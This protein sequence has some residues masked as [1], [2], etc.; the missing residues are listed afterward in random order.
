MRNM[1]Y[2]SFSQPTLFDNPIFIVGLFLLAIIFLILIII[3]IWRAWVRK[4]YKLP[5]EL[6]SVIL[7]VAVPKDA[8]GVGKKETETGSNT[9]Q[10]QEQISW[11]ENLWSTFGAI[12]PPKAWQAW[13]YG[14]HDEISLEIVAQNRL[15]YFYVVAPKY[16]EQFIEQQ[17]QAQYPHAQIEI[18]EDYNIFAPSSSVA[19]ACLNLMKPDILSLKTYR[20]MEVDPLNSL[21]NSLSKLSDSEGAVIQIMIRPVAKDWHKKGRKIVQEIMSGKKIDDVLKKIPGR[22]WYDKAA[23]QTLKSIGGLHSA[24]LVSESKS[25][26]ELPKQPQL[27]PLDQETIKSIEE[28]VAKASMETN[29]RV[30]VSAPD[31]STATMNLRNILNSFGQYNIYEYGNGFKASGSKKID[32]IISDIIHRRFS[33]NFL[34]TLNTEELASVYHFPLPSC[35]TPNIHW[36][37]ARRAPAPTNMPEQGIILGKNI[38]RGKETLVKLQKDDRRRH[39]YI[40]GMT[41]TGKSTL[42]VN[43]AVQDIQNGEGVCYIDPHGTGIEDILPTIPESRLQ[44]VIYFDPGFTERPIGLNMLEAKTSAEQDFATQEMIE[45][46]YKLMPSREMGGPMFEHYMRNAMLLLMADKDNPGTIVEIPRVFVDEEFRQYKLSK[47]HD[48]MVKAFW[49]KEYVAAQRGSSG[50]DMLSY[51]ISK[52]GRFIENEMMRNVIGQPYSGFNIREIM[53]HKKILLVNLSKGKIGETNSDLLGLIFVS[54]LQIAALS[55]ADLP[56][57][58]RPDFY[59]YID[60]FQN[61]VTDS[62]ATILAEARKYRLNLIMAHQYISQLIKNQDTKV[63][64]AVFGNAGTMICYRIGVEDT[65]TMAKQYAPVFN[66]YDLMNIEK[67]QA[68]VR[69]LINNE[70]A[71]PFNMMAFPPV[72]GNPEIVDVVKEYSSQ[73]YGRPK[74]E[75]EQEISERSKLGQNAKDGVISNP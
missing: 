38:Y 32:K 66:E 72:K 23:N 68:Y 4:N 48:L 30:V 64:D 10:I 62:I 41:G 55:R 11:A 58:E 51:V 40:I 37:G 39:L 75:V 74:S 45:I 25:K 13:F 14:R 50:A 67:Y 73:K 20:K 22:F 19:A 53:D 69:L 46:F 16:L 12:K 63:R 24:F 56:E 47:C 34:M 29:I 54:K 17:I 42:M 52:T 9:A 2:S 35:A 36:L 70:A 3:L 31:N 44:D 15:I 49:E 60:E 26:D 71:R 59:L 57:N 21:T 18:E 1:P 61:Y 27:T 5:L 7:S 28:K 33:K 8:A 43:L 6:R 65:E